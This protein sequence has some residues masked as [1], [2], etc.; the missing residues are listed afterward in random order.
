MAREIKFKR[1][2]A[3]NWFKLRNPLRIIF[4]S[5]LIS[6]IRHIPPLEAKNSLYRNLL[7]VKIGKDVAISPD[8]ILDPFFPELIEIDDGTLIGWGTRIFTH[9]FWLDRV[10]IDKVKIGKNVFIGGF[11]VIRPGVNIGK[12][13]VIASNSFVNKNVKNNDV[14]GGVPIKS[15][16]HKIR[17]G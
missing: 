2:A 6:L 8:V 7:G 17:K 15:I 11:S 3:R 10:R 5:F 1:N 4:N 12:N 13:S 9:E 14:V 16:K